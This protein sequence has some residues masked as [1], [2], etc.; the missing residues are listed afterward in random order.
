MA[1]EQGQDLICTCGVCKGEFPA[2]ENMTAIPSGDGVMQYG[3]TCPH[4]DTFVHSYFE[5]QEISMLRDKLN[6]VS[7]EFAGAPRFLKQKKWDELQAAKQVF[8]RHFNRVQKRM[9]LKRGMK[10][11][12]RT[13]ESSKESLDNSP[14]EVEA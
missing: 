10:L 8:Q 7:Q 11:H 13:R 5:T 3:L 14:S 12:D 4:C 6:R 1:V 2:K 9:R